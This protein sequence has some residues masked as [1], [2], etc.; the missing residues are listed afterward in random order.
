M[1]NPALKAKQIHFFGRVLHYWH[2]GHSWVLKTP[3]RSLE[4]AYKAVLKIQELEQ[5]HFGGQNISF[6]SDRYSHNTFSYFQSDLNRHLGVIKLRLAEFKTSQLLLRNSNYVFLDKLSA[7]DRIL[8]K[9]EILNEDWSSLQVANS[10][11]NPSLKESGQP[12]IEVK[13]SSL[14]LIDNKLVDRKNKKL[15]KSPLSF[16]REINSGS[17]EELLQNIRRNRR[18]TQQ[19]IKFIVL[20]I[21]LPLFAQ[22]FAKQVL[23]LPLVDRYRNGEENA[24]FI[25]WEMKEEA[26]KELQSFEEGLKF[27]TLLARAPQITSEVIE[28]KVSEKANELA[29]EFSQKGNNAIAN[30]FADLLGLFAFAGVIILN[31]KGVVAFKSFL[32]RIVFGLS[33]SAKAFIIILFTDM[34][35]GFHSPHGWEV[36]LEGLANHLGIPAN[37]SAIFLFIA[38]FPVILDA[39]FKYWIFRYLNQISPS[40]VATLKN[41]NE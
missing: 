26:I 30:I 33:D 34:F 2:L 36:L 25:N 10:S 27:E 15:P 20:L 21:V 31:P 8:T 37:H 13:S 32:N 24:I 18:T 39:I 28:E 9:Y 17:E 3:E 11:L 29:Q 35:V 14:S 41:M 7:I 16:K 6:D 4:E 19:A 40:A 23:I 5:E 1:N 22:I 12:T 38:T